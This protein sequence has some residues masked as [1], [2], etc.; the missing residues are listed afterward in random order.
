MKTTYNVHRQKQ[1]S[2]TSRGGLFTSCGQMKNPVVGASWWAD[3][4]V[5]SR[6]GLFPREHMPDVMTGSLGKVAG[7][8]VRDFP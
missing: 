5:S 8:G 1:S 7:S 6:G 3:N 2:E 4:P